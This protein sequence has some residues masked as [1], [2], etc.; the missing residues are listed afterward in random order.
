MAPSRLIVLFICTH[1]SSR[2]QMA[3]GFLRHLYGNRYAA[4]SAGTQ[5]GQVNPYAVQV[6]AEVGVDLSKHRSKS[7]DGFLNSEIDYVI[8]VCDSAKETCPIFPG[9]KQIQHKS[10]EDP[11]AAT[12]TQEQIL[13]SFRVV[14][15]QIRT[16]IETKFRNKDL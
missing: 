11:S 8:T 14:R 4:H 6:M 12:G 13:T 10:F 16:W 5:P 9:G 3:E 7:I 15:D 2:S 1:N